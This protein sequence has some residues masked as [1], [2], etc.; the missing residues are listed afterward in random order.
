M[1]TE[2][3]KDRQGQKSKE[4][5]LRDGNNISL[6]QSAKIDAGKA[7]LDEATI[8][9]TL[10]VGAGITGVTTALLLQKTGQRCIIADAH[11][12]GFGTSSGTTAHIN[13]FA[14]TTYAETEKAFSSQAAQLFADSIAD[15][16]ALIDENIKTYNIDC[17]FEWK[18]AYVYAETEKEV[19]QLDDLYEG[20]LAVDVDVTQADRVP[21]DV[22]FLKAIVFPDQAQFHPLKYIS[23]LLNEFL[24]LG[25]V[26][27][28]NTLI[29]DIDTQDG[30][31]TAKSENISIRAKHVVY[32]THIPPGG[33]NVLHFRNA[34]YR[35][36]VLAAVLANDAYPED[37]IY[38]MQDPYHY[39][40][41]HSIDGQKYLIIGGSDHKTGHGDPEKAFEDLES[42][43]RQYYPVEKIAYKWSAQYYV[44]ADGLPYIGQLPAAPDHIYAA[45]GFNGNGMILGTV[46]AIVLSEL[47]LTGSNKYAQIFDP[48]R[49]KP[50]AG[51]A[52]MV[53]E[54]ADVA[55]HFVADRLLTEEI[56]SVGDIEVESGAV[57]DLKGHKVA[58]YKGLNGEIYAL[59]PICTH[60]RCVVNWNNSEKSWDCP[61]HGAR[62]DI[63][64][65]VLTGPARAGLEKIILKG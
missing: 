19:K 21:T 22:P 6:W 55:Y 56:D 5:Q 34:P 33:I 13:T 31:H 26:I 30:V 35:S 7:V 49:I 4:G 16:V 25:G 48:A 15:S 23:G 40:R 43:C 47:I 3:D 65:T 62:F 45:T 12:A 2:K 39:L 41:T 42:Y 64:G 46:S 44:P 60:A 50:V 17:D 20:A 61:C 37:L 27:L 14:D 18:K 1:S 53:K 52:Q 10:I 11:T 24:S 38:D 54:N 29:A 59:N 57:V 9:D 36:Y 28:E 8:Y 51:F 58:V 63:D 32:A